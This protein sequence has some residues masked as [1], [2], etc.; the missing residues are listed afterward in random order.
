M[1]FCEARC[2]SGPPDGACAG[3]E[4]LVAAARAG[5]AEAL[6]RLF[7][8]LTP[9]A[10]AQAKRLCGR[11]A[12]AQDI[13]QLALLHALEHLADLRQPDRLAGWMRRIVTNTWRMEER[14]LAIRNETQADHGTGPAVPCEG[15]RRLDAQRTLGRVL[16]SAPLLPPLLAETFR[17]RVLEGLSTQQ[18]ADVLGI[19]PE[20]VRARL[21]RAR[22]RLRTDGSRHAR[23]GAS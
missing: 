1:P 9:L 2:L 11:A 18:T 3:R 5:D 4:C 19:S 16:A 7:A 12:L 21:K 15:E 22:E 6:D 10:L 13:A 20:A 23:Q 17:L 14:S 8:R